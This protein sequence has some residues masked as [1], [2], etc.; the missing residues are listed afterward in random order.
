MPELEARLRALAADVEWPPTPDLE[1]A[2]RAR[3]AARAPAGRSRRRRLLA[4]LLAALVLLPAA[5]A[6]AFPRARA[7]V[8][9][10]LGLRNVTVRRVP[11]PP[12]AARPELE[13]DLGRLVT[14]ARA[15]RAAGFAAALPAALGPP[16]RV[17]LGARRIS[18]VYA[19]RPGLPP[20]AGVDA[21]L[22]V[23]ESRG[24]IR[25]QYLRKLLLGGTDVEGSTS[26][27][28]AARSSREGSTPTST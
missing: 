13:A 22:I 21:G 20:L 11:A 12:P 19:P 6:V 3:P 16:D 23:T 14:L 1:R 7:D 26:A 2:V 10:W 17:R 5:G 9:E 28:A 8:L 25:G 24:G 4:A 27:R 18:L 15:E